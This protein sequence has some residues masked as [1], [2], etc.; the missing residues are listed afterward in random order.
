MLHGLLLISLLLPLKTLHAPLL[1]YS[2]GVLYPHYSQIQQILAFHSPFLVLHHPYIFIIS[3]FILS[4]IVNMP[5]ELNWAKTVSVA[6]PGLKNKVL[7]ISS[8]T[9]LWEWPKIIQ[10]TFSSNFSLT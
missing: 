10:S 5:I 2:L 3:P 9:G 6:E 1:F 8:L 4:L 7:L